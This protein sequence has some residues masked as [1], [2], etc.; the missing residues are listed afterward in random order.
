MKRCRGRENIVIIFT[1]WFLETVQRRIGVVFCQSGIL[2][3]TIPQKLDSIALFN[4]NTHAAVS[5]A[6]QRKCGRQINDMTHD[7]PMIDTGHISWEGGNVDQ[8]LDLF[9][10]HF[11]MVNKDFQNHIYVARAGKKYLAI[12]YDHAQPKY[13][14]RWTN[15]QIF[16]KMLLSKAQIAYDCYVLH[17]LDNL[18]QANFVQHWCRLRWRYRYEQSWRRM[19]ITLR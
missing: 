11:L 13:P 14:Q 6:T 3:S 1:V 2:Q 9:C 7:K 5:T 15:L 18:F 4:T 10:Y 16:A 12:N 17:D 8:N 19:S